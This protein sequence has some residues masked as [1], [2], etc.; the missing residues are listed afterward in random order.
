MANKPV[1]YQIWLDIGNRGWYERLS[2]PLTHPYVLSRN[3]SYGNLWTDSDEVSTGL[4]NL[5]RLSLGL[6]RRCRR[7][8]FLGVSE[9]G[10][11]G[12]EH[13]GPFLQAIQ[14]V[15]QSSAQ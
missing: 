8:V 7:K 14:R 12:Y 9:L 1:D 15:L 4:E 5:N 13:R 11:Q 6:L 3:W 2:Q 10:E